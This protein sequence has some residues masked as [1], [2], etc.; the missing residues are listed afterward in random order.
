L[1]VERSALRVRAGRRAS[2]DRCCGRSDRWENIKPKI[3]WITQIQ[4]G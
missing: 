4:S 2:L 3:T 1:T